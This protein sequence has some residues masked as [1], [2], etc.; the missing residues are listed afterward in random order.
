MFNISSHLDTYFASF[1]PR[2][3]KL[4]GCLLGVILT[5]L[6]VTPVRV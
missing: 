1:H 4:W 2:W 6:L 3:T 5:G